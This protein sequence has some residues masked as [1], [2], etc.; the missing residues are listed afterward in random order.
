MLG[1]NASAP[2]LIATPGVRFVSQI[3]ALALD[4]AVGAGGDGRGE[5][6]SSL[7]T[8]LAHPMLKD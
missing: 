7:G 1:W 3:D 6:A 2:V 5:E 4:L 8:P